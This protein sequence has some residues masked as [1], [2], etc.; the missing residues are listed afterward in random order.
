MYLNKFV[1]DSKAPSVCGFFCLADVFKAE[2]QI[3]S[4]D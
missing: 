2:F 1:L 3:E 4:R